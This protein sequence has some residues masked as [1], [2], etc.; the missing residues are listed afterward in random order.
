MKKI[1]ALL[2]IALIAPTVLAQS[3]ADNV[4]RRLADLLAP[5]SGGGPAVMA[6]QPMPSQSG[7]AVELFDAPLKPYAG[8]PVRL[9]MPPRREVKPGAILAGVPL[10]SYRDATPAPQQ[11]ELPTKP[12][13]RLPSLDLH[14][15]LA[16]P[17][18]AQAAKDRASLAEPAFKAS[19]DAAMKRL[20][21]T[22]D[23]PLPFTPLNLPDPFEHQCYG[24]L[25]NPPSESTTPPVVPSTKPKQ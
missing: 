7:K 4:E 6:K 15:P 20:T 21:P 22:R 3:G 2:S 23:K 25:R 18:L 11:V 13:I 16:L 14:T 1:I 9:P 8:L 12:L 24:E 5:G 10:V 19:V 17:I